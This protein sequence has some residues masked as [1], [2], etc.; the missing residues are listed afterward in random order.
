[1]HAAASCLRHTG[2]DPCRQTY[3]NG[4]H[5]QQHRKGKAKGCQ[6]FR[7]KKGDE[8]CIREI[9]RHDGKQTPEGGQGH[10]G[11][12]AYGPSREHGVGFVVVGHGLSLYLERINEA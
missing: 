4:N 9:R 1:M 2:R 8:I 10:A 5:N 7:T 6:R 11:Q 12:L 3:A